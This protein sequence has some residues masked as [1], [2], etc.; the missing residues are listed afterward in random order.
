MKRIIRHASL[1]S[2]LGA[3]ELVASWLGWQ[4][5][6]HCEISDFCNTV[7]NYWFPNSIGYEDIKKTD[8]SEWR[9]RVD[10][11]TGGFPCQPFSAAG[12][13]LGADDNRYLWPEMLR[14]IREIQPTFIVGENV[15][16]ILSMV[17][18]G[19]AVKVGCEASLFDAS[20]NVYRKEQQFVTETICS[21]LE[22][23]GYSV[24]AFVIPA[25][26]VG[27]PHKRNRVWFIAHR[28]DAGTED[29]QPAGQDGIHAFGYASDSHG[30]G[31][32]HGS[33][34][35]QGRQNSENSIRD[36]PQGYAR[37][38]F[39]SRTGKICS[40]A[41]DTDRFRGNELLK[42]VQSS[43]PN[44]ERIDSLG[45]QWTSSD[46]NGERRFPG[47]SHDE[48]LEKAQEEKRDAKQPVRTDRP[49]YWWREFPTV[50]PVCNGNDG[51]PFDVSRLS[52]PFNLWVRESIKALGNSMVPQVVMEILLAIENELLKE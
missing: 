1:F 41:P 46:P 6:F 12:K 30:I 21:D 2:G 32:Y 39:Q 26:S 20:D 43:K 19:S 9:G 36:I 16:G 13:R 44:G 47:E 24:Q 29:L 28:P 23:E 5:V 18:P 17:Q 35:W 25:C 40:A 37:G 22:R 42:E 3:P 49:Q 27:A 33:G 52:I 11:L 38:Q 15:A 50:P 10:V 14:A 7:L 31:L 8:F 45:I 34:I 4:N 51:L 48:L